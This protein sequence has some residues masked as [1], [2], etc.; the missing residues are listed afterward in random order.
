M[1]KV[2]WYSFWLGLTALALILISLIFKFE[3]AIAPLSVASS[4]LIAF[5]MG[6]IPALKLYQ[7]TGWIIVAIV[8]GLIYP[9]AFLKWGDFDLRNKWLILIVI[10]VVMFGMGTQMSIRDFTGIKTMS[11]GV[12]VGILCQ[13]SIM[14]LTGYALT[15]IFNFDPEIAAGI[16]L[17]GSC[18][19]GLASNVMVFLARANLTLSVTLTAVATL[20]APIMTPFLMKVLA[21]TYVEVK[22]MDMCIQII[23]IVI[24]P[25]GAAFLYDAYKNGSV[26]LKKK[27]NVLFYVAI[28]WLFIVFGLRSSI[29]SNLSV[30]LIQAIVLVN[31]ISGSLIFGKLFYLAT[32]FISTIPQ[33]MPKLSMFG[34]VYF[35]VVTTAASRDNILTIGIVMLLVSV[36]HNSLGYTFGYWISRALGLDKQSCRTV[37]LEVGLQN[38]GMASGLAGVMGKLATIGLAAAIFSPW[39]NISGSILANFW[40]KKENKKDDKK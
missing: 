13:F 15:R 40:R 11:K 39:M 2:Q 8:C 36:M 9:S 17:I 34:I 24:V 31:F 12:L 28:A 35:T 16:I 5:G 14:P 6:A 29:E 38:G 22:F 4:L 32:V 10:Q 18:S 23:K 26:M 27:L 30:G 37:A 21:G 19:S 25:I 20:L 33:F 1:K 7:Y 3:N